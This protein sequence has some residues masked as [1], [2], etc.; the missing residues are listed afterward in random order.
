MSVL[1]SATADAKTKT[2]H[3]VYKGYVMD[4][5]YPSVKQCSRYVNTH[6]GAERWRLW[7][8]RYEYRQARNVAMHKKGWYYVWSENWAVAIINAEST[9]IPTQTNGPCWGLFQDNWYYHCQAH[10]SLLLIGYYN[11]AVSAGLFSGQAK[12]PWRS[13]DSKVRIYPFA[14]R[15]HKKAKAA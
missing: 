15:V 12:G 14:A 13:D 9:G 11:V 1:F 10:P 3:V 7:V 4:G 6:S 8:R 2:Q 5:K